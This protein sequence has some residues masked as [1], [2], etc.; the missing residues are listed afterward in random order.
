MIK[1]VPGK[2]DTTKLSIVDAPKTGVAYKFG[3]YQE[4]LK[5]IKADINYLNN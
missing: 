3:F 4:E 5:K 1:L 2:A